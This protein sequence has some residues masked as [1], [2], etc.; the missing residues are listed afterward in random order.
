VKLEAHGSVA[1]LRMQAGKANSIGP[2]FLSR[3][4]ALLD[5]VDEEDPA[6]LVLVGEKRSFSA[7]LALP[8]LMGKSRDEMGA[9]ME[10]FNRTMQRVFEQPRP[11]VA[12]INGHAIAGGCVLAMQADLRVMARG[13]F[14]IGLNEVALG[15][16]LPTIVLESFRIQ[17]SEKALRRM[18]QFGELVRSEDALALGV[19]DEVV[20]HDAVEERALA[21]AQK[22]VADCGRAGF[23]HVKRLIRRPVIQA[24]EAWGTQDNEAWLDSF[25]GSDAMDRIGAVVARFSKKG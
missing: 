17:V 3:F 13:D 9:F 5:Q 8:E 2:E 4:N 16:G 20:D 6:A 24:V 1:L 10:L 22:A 19:V 14:S 21:L 11:C 23:V 12:A 25:F 15:I 7:G 18:A